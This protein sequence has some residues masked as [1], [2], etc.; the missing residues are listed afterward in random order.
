MTSTLSPSALHTDVQSVG[1]PASPPCSMMG[2][3]YWAV[4]SSL[5]N[6]EFLR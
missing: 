3:G 2:N 6:E 5:R 4:H 1:V